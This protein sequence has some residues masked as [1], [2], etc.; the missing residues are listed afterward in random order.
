LIYNKSNISN[1][2]H[3]NS[4]FFA[5]GNYKAVIEYSG[6]TFTRSLTKTK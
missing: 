5:P 4:E 1:P 6:V 2:H 3:I